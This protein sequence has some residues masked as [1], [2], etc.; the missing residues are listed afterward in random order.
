MVRTIQQLVFLVTWF[1]GQWEK[2]QP[3]P[4]ASHYGLERY[5]SIDYCF[6][7]PTTDGRTDGQTDTQLQWILS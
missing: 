7:K 6:A 5:K 4:R 3:D 1:A 2:G